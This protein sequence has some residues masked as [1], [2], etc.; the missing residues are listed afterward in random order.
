MRHRMREAREATGLSQAQAA[1]VIGVSR[2]AVLA[3]ES[4]VLAVSPA[5]L[6][7]IAEAY[8]VSAHW[9]STGESEATPEMMEGLRCL[10]RGQPEQ[11]RRTVLRIM[12]RVAVR[13][14]G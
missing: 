8:S 10:L 9:L 14:G 2:S 1:G 6:A 3:W 12:E 11:T 4:G 13:H 7:A 5:K